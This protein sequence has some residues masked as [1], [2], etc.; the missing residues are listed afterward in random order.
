M[1]TKNRH[2]KKKTIEIERPVPTIASNNQFLPR[3]G[4]AT[5]KNQNNNLLPAPQI[6]KK[7]RKS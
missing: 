1:Q 3:K 4:Q 6:Q 2:T 7:T 5:R